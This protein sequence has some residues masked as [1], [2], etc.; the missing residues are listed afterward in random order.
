MLLHW[1]VSLASSCSCSEMLY[2]KISLKEIT[3]LLEKKCNFI[4]D[5]MLSTSN[6]R[7]QQKAAMERNDSFMCLYVMYIRNIVYYF[8]YIKIS[9]FHWKN[10]FSGQILKSRERTHKENPS[11]VSGYFIYRILLLFFGF[12]FFIVQKCKLIKESI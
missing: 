5:R 4:P 6:W 7:W 12:F 8:F 2:E 1:V 3:S 9:C 10:P 11:K